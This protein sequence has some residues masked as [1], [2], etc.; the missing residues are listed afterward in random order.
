MHKNHHVYFD[1]CFSSV[2]L[3]EHLESNDTYACATVRCNRKEKLVCQK[4]NIVFTKWQDKRDVSVIS[5]NCSPLAVDLVVNRRNQQVSKPAV[6]DQYNKQM[7]VLI[8]R[9]SCVNIIL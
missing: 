5:T 1:N 9:I 3:L 2:K 6:I 4:G 7:G 8:W